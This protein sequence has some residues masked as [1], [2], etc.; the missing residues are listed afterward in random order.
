M[1]F[2]FNL[3]AEVIEKLWD[4]R[5]QIC[6]EAIVGYMDTLAK[7]NEAFRDEQSL[8]GIISS[9]KKKDAIDM[10][11]AQEIL[12]DN[13]KVY[14]ALIAHWSE[15]KVTSTDC[16]TINALIE[17]GKTTADQLI[18]AIIQAKK[19]AEHE[20]RVKFMPAVATWLKS[21]KWK[22]IKTTTGKIDKLA[23]VNEEAK[24]QLLAKLEGK[25]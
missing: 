4:D 16:E 24:P 22:A 17:A 10:D 19:Q 20:D 15:K 9:E 7:E 18:E 1:A 8:K 23:K 5:A 3:P 14:E 6:W 12:G 11:Y 2:E 25:R 13:Y 21:G